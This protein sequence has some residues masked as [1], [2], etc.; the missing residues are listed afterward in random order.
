[1]TTRNFAPVEEQLQTLLRG[2]VDV[3]VEAE[4]RAKL[5]RSHQTGTPLIIKAGFDPTA[6]DLHLG[7]TVLLH[8]MRQ[9]QRLGHQVVFLIGDS[10]AL[11]GDPSGRNATRPPLTPE[12]IAVN[13][14]TYK[15][16]VFKVL[17]PDLTSVRFN[18]EWLQP[19]TFSDLVRLCSNVTVAQMLE[20]EDFKNRMAERRPLA[21]H[22]L[23]YPLTQAYDSVAL[24]ADVELGGKDQLFNLMLGRDL[25]RS[26]GM[27]PQCIL[28][29]PILEGVDAEP[30]GKKMSKS[31]GNYVGVSES[32]DQQVLKLM[33]I[34]DNLMWRY[35]ELLSDLSS[36][37]IAAR[38]GQ[39][40]RGEAQARAVKLQLAREL[41]TRFHGDAAATAAL[42]AYEGL[43]RGDTLPADAPHKTVVVPEGGIQPAQLA[44][45]LGFSKSK[46]EALE[47]IKQG[48]LRHRVGEAGEFITADDKTPIDWAAGSELQV[49]FGKRDYARVT[50]G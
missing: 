9:F 11:I 43:A 10:T 35:F 1:M 7:H 44:V 24:K 48:A 32:A 47:R 19:L 33:G 18:S 13:A 46:R 22:E 39:V 15:Q 45:E 2:V 8:K 40:E 42:A 49:R 28:T 17:D 41:V 21:L 31:L 25:M 4:L 37:E 36:S 27:E 34:S 5:T 23:L 6:P 16:Q 26:R 29:V 50:R 14:V 30:G 12:E 3:H 20:R 38:K